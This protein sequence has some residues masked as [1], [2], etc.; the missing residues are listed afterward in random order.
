[1]YVYMHSCMDHD[2]IHH[3]N[4]YVYALIHTQITITIYNLSEICIKREREIDV[5]AL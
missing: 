2:V 4:V 5:I 3:Y 1:M